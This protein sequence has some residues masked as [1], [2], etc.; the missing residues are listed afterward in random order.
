MELT[1]YNN[2]SYKEAKKRTSSYSFHVY[3]NDENKILYYKIDPGKSP[4]WLETTLIDKDAPSKEKVLFIYEFEGLDKLIVRL[5]L[6]NDERASEFN[7]NPGE[8]FELRRKYTLSYYVVFMGIFLWIL[9]PILFVLLL[10]FLD[11]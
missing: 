9:L 7:K 4:K 6:D 10:W 5:P 8:T 2:S 1:F 3:Q 11:G